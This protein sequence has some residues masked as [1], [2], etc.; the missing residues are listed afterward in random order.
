MSALSR[1]YLG[2]ISPQVRSQL[3]AMDGANKLFAKKNPGASEAR[4]R[5]NMHA[6]LSRKFVESMAEYQE[7]QARFKSKHR[8]RM[9]RQYRMVQPSISQE[10]IDAAL[11]GGGQEEVF[12]QTVLQGPGHAQARQ[13][14]S[15]IQERRRDIDK[16]VPPD[17]SQVHS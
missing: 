15:D 3:K 14:L 4:I 12:S 7:V 2:C 8:E 6:T 9:A 1:L 10:E 13:E 5:T 17:T 16:L 11:D